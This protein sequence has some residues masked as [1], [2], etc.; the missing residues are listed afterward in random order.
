MYVD[1]CTKTPFGKYSICRPRQ[2]FV[3]PR[4]FI[5]NSFFMSFFFLVSSLEVPT[6]FKSSTYTII[7]ANP[8]SDLMKMHGHIGLFTYPSF[9]KYLLRWLYHMHPDYFNPYKDHCNLIKY[10]PRAFILFDSGNLNPSRIF[11]YI[12]LSMDTYKY[13]IVTS[14]RCISSPFEIVKLIKK[15]NVIV[16]MTGEY[17]SL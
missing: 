5:S 12:S 8:I 14:M 13:V 1:W 4:S 15:R 2:N 16:S 7:I 6:R 11:M 17:V 10:M 9:S 3:F